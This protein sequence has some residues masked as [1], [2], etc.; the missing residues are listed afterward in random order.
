ME[1]MRLSTVVRF[2]HP[3][4][5]CTLATA[6][7]TPATMHTVALCLTCVRVKLSVMRTPSFR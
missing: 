6:I 3:V 1:R 7:H 5:M 4:T 2:Q